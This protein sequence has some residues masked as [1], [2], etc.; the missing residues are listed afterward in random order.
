MFETKDINV[1]HNRHLYI[2]GS[3]IPT[4]L[5]INKYQ[6]AFNLA[7]EKL[8]ILPSTFTGNEYT[9]FGNQL[10]PQIRDYINA[11]NDTHFVPDTI[12]ER[13]RRLR[14]NCDG[15]DRE[16]DLLLEIKTHGKNF[17]GP[18][19]EKYVSQMQMYMYVFGLSAGW[20]ALYERPSN[21]DVEFD[22]DRLNIEVIERDESYIQRILHAVEV[23][24][25][26][27]EALKA[28]PDMNE[29]EFLEGGSNELSL[30]I[31]GLEKLEFELS[32]YKQ[33]EE[34]YK[35]MKERL[36]ELMEQHDVKSLTS[37]T[38]SIT[39]VLPTTTSSF[40]RAG[41]KKS[42]PELEKKYTKQSAKKGF[43]K[44]TMKNTEEEN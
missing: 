28:N 21:F 33:L 7:K 2:G 4:I 25:V 3:D 5:G 12:I 19:R 35:T 37:E 13:E 15:L 20:L 41:L 38:L 22:S 42:H 23:F 10:E 27:C 39:R 30:L 1:T 6:S 29:A 11:V 32:N 18:T 40:D 31:G 24:W 16:H 43:V 26:R 17:D 9:E 14:G 8:K 34:R 44:I 36:Y